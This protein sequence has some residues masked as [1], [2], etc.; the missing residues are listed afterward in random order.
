MVMSTGRD[1]GGRSD[2]DGPVTDWRVTKWINISNRMNLSKS[3]YL[4]L[5]E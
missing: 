1:Q 4:F 3:S 5:D 2:H